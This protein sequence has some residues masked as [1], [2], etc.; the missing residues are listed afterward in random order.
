MY[1]TDLEGL[2][3][4]LAELDENFARAKLSPL[5]IG[6]LLKQR[7][8]LIECYQ[9]FLPAR[10]DFIVQPMWGILFYIWILS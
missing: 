10:A 5:E 7:D 6:N 9:S 2:S 8:I 1:A 3:A 4:E